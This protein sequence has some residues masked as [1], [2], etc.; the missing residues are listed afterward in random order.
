MNDRARRRT[1]WVSAALVGLAAT[2]FAAK[3]LRPTWNTP[4]SLPAPSGPREWPAG[5]GAVVA[6]DEKELVALLASGPSEIW[7][8]DRTYHGDF[9]VHRALTLRGTGK[10]VLDGSGSGTVLEI[11][12]DGVSIENLVVRDSGQSNTREDAAIK[13]S[14]HGVTLRDLRTEDT[15]FGIQLANCKSCIIDRVHV[16]GTKGGE[17]RGDGIKVWESDGSIVQSSL[18]D[19]VRDVVVWY[20]KHVTVKNTVVKKSR[21]GTHFMYAHDSLAEG[22]RYL[23]NEV[24]IFVMYSNRVQGRENVLAGARGAA[25]M[26]FGF[27]ESETV[28]LEK[29]WVVANTTGIYLDQT[30]RSPNQEVRFEHNVLALNDVALRTHGANRGILFRH[31]DL[32][33]NASVGEVDGGGDMQRL[34]F[35]DNYWSDYAGYDLDHDGRGDVAYEVKRLSGDLTDAHPQLR[36]FRGTVAMN[37]IDAIAEAVPTFSRRKLLTDPVPSFERKHR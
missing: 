35:E 36:F 21:Y 11:E 26:G 16:A 28:T 12:A 5:A 10:S 17:L 31:N 3:N 4:P 37:L 2:A 32:H 24:G 20:S 27:K 8:A 1:A 22:N 6:A 9:T 15:L 7:L 18:V 30:P 33:G 25:G 13:A 14:G 19:G 29:N 34:V 23:E